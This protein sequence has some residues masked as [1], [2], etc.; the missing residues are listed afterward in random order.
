MA[1]LKTINGGLLVI[2]EGLDGAGKTT[3]LN[4]A[5]QELTRQGYLVHTS[6]NLGGSP[7]GE[8][9]RKV[10]LSPLERPATTNFFIGVAVQEALAEVLKAEKDKGSIILL[11]RGP[12]SLVAY[13]SFGE[14]VDNDL[15]WQYG[16]LGFNKFE[17][18]EILY[19]KL[20]INEAFN[21]A[22]QRSSQS[23]YFESKPKEYYERVQGLLDEGAKRFSAHEV[24][25]EQ[26]IEDLHAQIMD[27]VKLLIESKT[28][29]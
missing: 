28:K 13:Q 20:P 24:K 21:R 15:V 19:L 18:D 23:D 8:E 6:R 7:I 26:S 27:Q 5:T 14:G 2:F 3:Q 12:M 25:A 4:L 1:E 29:V 22:H 10:L 11:D 17:P 9:L 16:D